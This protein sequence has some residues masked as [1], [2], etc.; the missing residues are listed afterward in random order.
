[1]VLDPFCGTGT[2]GPAALALGRQFTGIELNQAF[3]ALAAGRLRQATQP[4]PTRPRAARRDR[5]DQAAYIRH[6]AP[7]GT[8]KAACYRQA[9]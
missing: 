6:R 8:G 9:T 1:M 3:A 4:D 5:H 2:T 7:A